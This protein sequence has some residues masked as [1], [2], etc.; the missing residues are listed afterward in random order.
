MTKKL[1]IIVLIVALLAWVNACTPCDCKKYKAS[2]DKFKVNTVSTSFF[3]L[4]VNE[5]SSFSYTQQESDTMEQKKVVISI[6]MDLLLAKRAKAR[7]FHFINSAYACSCAENTFNAT[8]PVTDLEIFALNDFDANHRA[9]SNISEYFVHL[10]MGYN[11]ARIIKKNITT[12]TI[13][14]LNTVRGYLEPGST[15]TMLYLNQ[16]PDINRNLRFKIVLTHQSG[17]QRELNT[18]ALYLIP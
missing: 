4:E 3:K 5:D 15:S 11:P 2:S 12:E 17:T 8:D 7:C 13:R 14:W 6:Q 16:A 9:G 10:E 1:S 18:D